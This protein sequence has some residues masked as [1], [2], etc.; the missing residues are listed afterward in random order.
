MGSDRRSWKRVAI[1]DTG[2]DPTHPDLRQVQGYD[3]AYND[4]SPEDSAG[5]GTACAG[6]AA[7]IANNARGVA[8]AAGGCSIM[9]VRTGTYSHPVDV[10]ANGVAYAAAHG[11]R[12]ISISLGGSSHSQLELDAIN[13]AYASGV[14]LFAA[15]GNSNASSIAYPAAYKNVIAVGAASPCGTRKRS[16]SSGTVSPGVFHDSLGVSC[17]NE[18][19]WGSNWG[20]A[21]KDDSAAVDIVGPTMLPTTD[22]QGA[23]GYSPS[24]YSDW[25]NGTSCATPYVAGVAALLLSQHPTWTPAQVRQRLMETA[26]DISDAQTPAGWDRYTG[27]GMVNAALPDLTPYLLAG[28]AKTIVPRSTADGSLGSVPAPSQLIGNGSTYL[29]AAKANLGT[30]ASGIADWGYRVDG[31]PTSIN[32]MNLESGTGTYVNNMPITVPGGRHV[33]SQ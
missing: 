12:I 33:L 2:V 8:G 4:T 32:N 20:R 22:I 5:H 9:S 16:A 14:V 7:G 27:Y 19:W 25:F 10:I 28:W 1:L 18:Y 17:D 24:G 31:A 13:A 23:G 29:N 15:T 30:V 11:A 21:V 6:V 26:I 3:F